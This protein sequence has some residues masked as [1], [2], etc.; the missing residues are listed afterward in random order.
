MVSHRFNDFMRIL[1]F[2]II[3]ILRITEL[4]SQ[5]TLFSDDPNIL[6]EIIEE[7]IMIEVFPERVFDEKDILKSL[8]L[9]ECDSFIINLSFDE[10]SAGKIS[11]TEINLK[12]YFSD[13]LSIYMNNKLLISEN[14]INLGNCTPINGN[15]NIIIDE[16]SILDINILKMVFENIDSLVLIEVDLSYELIDIFFFRDECEIKVNHRSY[17]DEQ[18]KIYFKK[19]KANELYSEM[20]SKLSLLGNLI[21]DLEAQKMINSNQENWKINR[22]IK[23]R[24]NNLAGNAAYIANLNCTIEAINIRIKELEVLLLE[25]SNK[26]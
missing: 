26:K 4:S 17:S 14:I 19:L 7:E 18:R 13:S 24:N 3:Y 16:E 12:P 25:N 2:L 9:F 20:N 11:D 23:C 8:S 21:D 22:K 10:K 15:T 1:I 6:Y 5:D